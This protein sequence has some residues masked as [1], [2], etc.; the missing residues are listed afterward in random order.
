MFICL[1]LMMV[2]NLFWIMGVFLISLIVYWVPEEVELLHSLEEIDSAIFH[3]EIRDK[4]VLVST[5]LAALQA[6]LTIC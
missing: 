6:Y 5:T 1:V 4:F 3:L 2:L